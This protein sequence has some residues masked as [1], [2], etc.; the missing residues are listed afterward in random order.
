MIVRLL[1]EARQ[2]SNTTCA[3]CGAGDLEHFYTSKRN[4]NT[5]CTDC[6]QHR[7]ERGLALGEVRLPLLDTPSTDGLACRSADS[8]LITQALFTVLVRANKRC[9]YDA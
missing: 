9:C 3:R 7:V 5:L 6:F 4:G 8:L 1:Y 2:A